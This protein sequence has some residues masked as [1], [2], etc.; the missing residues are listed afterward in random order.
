MTKWMDAIG[1]TIFYIA[2]YFLVNLLSPFILGI[3]GIEYSIIYQIIFASIIFSIIILLINRNKLTKRGWFTSF[4]NKELKKTLEICI[5]SVILVNF[6]LVYI[7]PNFIDGNMPDAIKRSF[8]SITNS[9]P[10]LILLTVGIL[11]PVAEEILFRGAIYNLI[12]DKFNK[13]AA[14]I[15]SA[16]LFAVIH[17]NLYQASYALIIGLFMGFI[18]MKTGSLWLTIIF[19][20]AYNTLSVIY[21]SL[22]PKLLELL[23]TKTYILPI[24]AV[25]LL[26]DSLK[27]FLIKRGKRK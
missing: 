23:I 22:N 8:D 10:F 18:I 7:F 4:N 2:L 26:F 19:H 6:L 14:V 11:A 21:G 17:M 15:V 25:L 16:I 24:I 5:A 1:Q 12:K 3:V 20:I 27:F 13:F 9:N